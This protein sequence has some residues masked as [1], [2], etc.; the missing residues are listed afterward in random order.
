MLKT[1]KKK[2]YSRRLAN[3]RTCQGDAFYSFVVRGSEPSSPV[4]LERLE[5]RACAVPPF[6]FRAQR[7]RASAPPSTLRRLVVCKGANSPV[8]PV[9]LFTISPTNRYPPSRYFIRCFS[10]GLC[11]RLDVWD[12]LACSDGVLALY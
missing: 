2:K 12:L 1:L 4:P 6:V 7:P 9:F 3:V 8:L 11:E 5:G 10:V